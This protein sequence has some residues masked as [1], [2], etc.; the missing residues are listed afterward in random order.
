MEKTAIIK[1]RIANCKKIYRKAFNIFA[2]DTW[3]N[4]I[5]N[6]I[7]LY[8]WKAKLAKHRFYI[9]LLIDFIKAL[10]VDYNLMTLSIEKK[11]SLIFVVILLTVENENCQREIN[12]C[13]N[14]V[15]VGNE[16]ENML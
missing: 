15:S 10:K 11:I 1:Q 13:Q 16:N 12:I 9:K 6:I 14:L 3:P 2:I 5:D 8:K 4:G 7:F